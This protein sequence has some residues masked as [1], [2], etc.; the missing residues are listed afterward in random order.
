MRCSEAV[1]AV[2]EDG[3]VVVRDEVGF[4][5]LQQLFLQVVHDISRN[6]GRGSFGLRLFVALRLGRSGSSTFASS[7]RPTLHRGRRASRVVVLLLLASLHSVATNVHS[8]RTRP[9]VIS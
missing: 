6:K 7:K 4:P 1:D 3:P 9:G 5:S 8:L 2:E